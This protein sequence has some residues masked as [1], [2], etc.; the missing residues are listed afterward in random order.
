[1]KTCPK[2]GAY[3]PDAS[4]KCLAC[5]YVL[6]DT[7]GT[8]G[9]ASS[10]AGAAA[11]QQAPNPFENVRSTVKENTSAYSDTGSQTRPYDYGRS[12]GTER[13]NYKKDRGYQHSYE[14]GMEDGKQ[15]TGSDIF[16]AILSYFGPLW[17]LPLLRKS[18]GNPPSKFVMFHA[19]QGLVLFI[20]DVIIAVFSGTT[21]LSELFNLISFI[22]GIIGIINAAKGQMKPLP[23][24]GG[25]TLI[26]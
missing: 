7:F 6:K 24:I 16:T 23:I 3:V 20:L 12:D 21:G 14:E 2:C 25:I 26:R 11:Q 13:Q 5:G 8:S 4:D 18:S 10:P 19:N 15:K 1:M 22:L 9:T 17:I